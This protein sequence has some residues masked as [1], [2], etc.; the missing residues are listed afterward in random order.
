M[1]PL[2]SLGQM[3]GPRRRTNMRECEC[4]NPCSFFILPL[5]SSII[6]AQRRTA[7]HL[8]TRTLDG[9]RACS[10]RWAGGSKIYASMEDICQT[11]TGLDLPSNRDALEISFPAAR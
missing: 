5:L 11:L 1:T 7:E 2:L 10:H 4:H 8:M 3:P 9:T 6:P